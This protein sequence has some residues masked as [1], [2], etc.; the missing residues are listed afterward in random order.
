[1]LSYNYKWTVTGFSKKK[2]DNVSKQPIDLI[3]L[4]PMNYDP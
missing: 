2:N 1:M 3:Q 4:S